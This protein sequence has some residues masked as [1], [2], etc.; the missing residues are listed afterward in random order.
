VEST[1]ATRAQKIALRDQ[2]VTG[3]SRR[4]LVEVSESARAIAG[5][6]LSSPE[7]RR[8][9]TV[10]CYVSID[11][12]P[13]TGPLLDGLL[14]IGRRVIVPVVQPD[15]D[16]DWAVHDGPDTLARARR[17]LLEPT[18]P[19]LGLEAVATADGVLTPGLA[20]DRSGMRLGQGGG[21]YD[22]ALGRVPV[23]TFVCTLLYDEELLDVVPTA[24]HDRPVTAVVTPA[25]GITRLRRPR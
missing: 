4:S 12:E 7:I 5:H 19:R 1:D 6:V 15:L 24:A 17:G 25:A 20:V 9:A 8:A 3:R 18:G 23:G 14:G 11:T 2:L 16:L 22:R 10:A 21:C 13:G